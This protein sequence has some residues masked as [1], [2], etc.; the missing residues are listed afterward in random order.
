MLELFGYILFVFSGVLFGL[1]GS[2]GSII[3]LPIFWYIFELSPDESKT[4]SLLLIFCISLFG[5]IRH[6]QKNNFHIQKTWLFIASTLVFTAFSTIFLFPKIILVLDYSFLR[7]FFSVVV[8]FAAISVFKSPSENAASHSK[9]MLLL[10]GGLVGLLTGLLGVGGGF[11]IVPALIL[12]VKLDIKQSAGIA[13]FI[14]MLNTF[15]AI[16]LEITVFDFQFQWDFI[17]FLLI[18][19]LIGILIGI[20]LLNKINLK[21]IKKMFSITLLF[22]SLIIFF[23]ELL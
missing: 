20:Y 21:L 8:F 10:I 18:S 5:T 6:R 23:I 9:I 1:F 13:L 22:L 17:I 19:G 7:I 11:I 12:F 15:L 3:M 16:I 4:Y 14:I 2:G